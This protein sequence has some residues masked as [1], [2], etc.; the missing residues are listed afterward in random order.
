MLRRTFKKL[1]NNF[2]KLFVKM[3]TF[4]AYHLTNPLLTFDYCSVLR[5]NPYYCFAFFIIIISFSFGLASLSS[6]E[7]VS[8]VLLEYFGCG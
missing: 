7:F 5:R 4:K 1:V 2:N 8:T 6:C 3:P